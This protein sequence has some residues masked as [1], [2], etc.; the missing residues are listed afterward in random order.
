[1]NDN[2]YSG[3]AGDDDSDLVEDEETEK[4]P[5]DAGDSTEEKG[6][7]LEEEGEE[8]ELVE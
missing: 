7:G 1:M 6:E 3:Y 8:E 4:N 5:D 2:L